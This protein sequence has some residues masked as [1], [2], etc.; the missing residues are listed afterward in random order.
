MPGYDF[1]AITESWFSS[2]A[3]AASATRSAAYKTYLRGCELLCDKGRGV[4]MM[5]RINHCWPP[6]AR[7]S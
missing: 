4:V 5:T 1:D 7:P 3:E 6:F 2:A